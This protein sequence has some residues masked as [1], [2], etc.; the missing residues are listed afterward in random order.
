MP[1]RRRCGGLLDRDAAV[2]AVH[3]E[4]GVLII[5][6]AYARRRHDHDFAGFIDTGSR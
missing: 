5:P 2:S 4:P 1:R 3:A 6:L